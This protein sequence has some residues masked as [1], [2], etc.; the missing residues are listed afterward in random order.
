MCV[1]TWCV[2]WHMECQTN[3]AQRLEGGRTIG[4]ILHALIKKIEWVGCVCLWVC[5]VRGIKWCMGD[6]EARRLKRQGC[7]MLYVPTKSNTISFVLQPALSYSVHIRIIFKRNKSTKRTK[8]WKVVGNA[9][10][11]MPC[12]GTGIKRLCTI[13]N[14]LHWQRKEQNTKKNNKKNSRD[15]INR[16]ISQV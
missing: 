16:H 2:I 3:V 7:Y 4:S 5:C 14:L 13:S 1:F 9:T 10:T 6:E 12:N 15:S 8:K 11:Y